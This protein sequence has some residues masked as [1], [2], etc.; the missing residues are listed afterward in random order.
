MSR[1][2]RL[3]KGLPI[4]AVLV[5]MAAPLFALPDC[6]RAARAA[7]TKHGVPF[8]ILRAI[9]RVESGRMT[10]GVFQPWPWAVNLD[11]KGLYFETRRAAA[12]YLAQN[13]AAGRTNFDVGCFQINNT[14]HGQAFAG[15][16]DMLDPNRN[17]DYAARFLSELFAEVGSWE[18]AV[19]HYHSRTPDKASRYQARFQQV[20]A[21]L[22]NA[23]DTITP[24]RVN[25]F[26][27]LVAGSGVLTR[28]SLVPETARGRWRFS[29][30]RPL[31]E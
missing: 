21:A 28:G 13:R 27:L 5:L 4:L 10:N 16:D 8:Q 23:E 26:P 30:A 18:I 2:H 31:T 9:A 14:W 25:P 1:C 11:G 12:A 15:I 3:W 6:D 29:T 17:A 22:P 7:A 19:G 24:D 20:F